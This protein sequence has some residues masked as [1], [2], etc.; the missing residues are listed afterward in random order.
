MLRPVALPL[1]PLEPLGTLLGRVLT[2]EGLVTAAALAVPAW[3]ADLLFGLISTMFSIVYFAAISGYYF[4]IVDHVGRRSPGLP[5]PSMEDLSPLWRGLACVL[6]VALPGVLFLWFG[7]EK[8]VVWGTAGLLASPLVASLYL[9]AAIVACTVANNALAALWPYF[10]IRIIARA[11]GSYARLVGRFLI[12]ALAFAVASMLAG[13][14]VG[15]IPFVGPL[16]ASA[17]TN[18]VL[19]GQALVVG[20]F[21]RRHASDFGYD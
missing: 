12:T 6:L 8:S 5:Y 13:L 16:L 18:L 20:D 17:A 4:Q 19:F 10:W 1:E 7:V 15:L 21:L 9:P 2:T 11:P 14:T 3:L